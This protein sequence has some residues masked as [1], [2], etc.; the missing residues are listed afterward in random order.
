MC[1]GAGSAASH[2][3]TL[4]NLCEK[5]PC[6]MSFEDAAT[7]PAAYGTAIAGLLEF[8][9]LKAGQVSDL[10]LRCGYRWTN[11]SQSVLIHRACGGVGLAALQVAKM[12]GADIYATVGNEE[13][14]KYL[15]ENFDLPRNRIFHSRDASFLGGI[16]RETDG[17]G[18]DLVLN[19]LSGDLLHATWKCVA[20]FGK[21]IEIGE[22]DLIGA[23]KL[24]LGSFLGGRSYTSVQLD[25]LVAKKPTAVKE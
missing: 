7:L 22:K 19:S 21:M 5:I 25:A 1:L 3:V 2:V 10:P 12:T 23:G 8:G 20:E 11:T 9:N 24:D 15:V 4:E 17:R 14:A 16:M 6:N 13:K 18:V